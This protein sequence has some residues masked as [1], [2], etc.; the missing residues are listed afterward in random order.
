MAI[1]FDEFT[2]CKIGYHGRRCNLKC[3]SGCDGDGSCDQNNATCT[4]G[5]KDGY[6]SNDTTCTLRT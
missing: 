1:F 3:G 4:H 2:G 5:C 6:Q